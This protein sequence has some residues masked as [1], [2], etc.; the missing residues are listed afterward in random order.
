MSAAPE[1]KIVVT[2]VGAVS[3]AGVGADV[4][5]DNL[6]AG[7]SALHR[8]PEWADEFPAQVGSMV[9]DEE[10]D[11]KQWMHPKEAR[12]QAR[13]THFAM[14]ASKMAVEDAKVG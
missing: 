4:Y 1:K 8:L 11:I 7:K 9:N 3:S 6:C 14:A 12:R 2:G 5:F 10:F 13:Y